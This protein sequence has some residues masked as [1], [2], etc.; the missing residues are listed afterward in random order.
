VKNK[1]QQMLEWGVI[2]TNTSPH[3]SPI[4]ILPNKYATERMF[5]N[6]RDLNKISSRIIVLCLG[7]MTSCI[8]CDISSTSPMTSKINIWPSE[9]QTIRHLNTAFK[10]RK[11]LY[12]W[13][14]IPFGL[15]NAWTIFV[16]DEWCTTS[17]FIF[18]CNSVLGCYL[19]FSSTWE[20]HILHL[21]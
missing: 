6:Y 1:L 14:V 11:G 21:M 20:D 8:C 3:K 7:S 9:T 4:I 18:I 2:R 12:E 16:F 15:C 13:L 5:I 19:I 17:L 10:T